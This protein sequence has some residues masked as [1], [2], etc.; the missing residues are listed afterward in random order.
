MGLLLSSAAKAWVDPISLIASCEPP[1]LL[2][3]SFPT[4]SQ[5]LPPLLQ[6]LQMVGY[7]GSS[8]IFL[9]WVVKRG[10]GELI[11]MPLTCEGVPCKVPL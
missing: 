5:S 3:T 10:Q 2:S 6:C 9:W 4:L 1:P 11:Q 8:P 7:S